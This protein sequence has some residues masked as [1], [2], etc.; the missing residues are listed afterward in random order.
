MKYE[1]TLDEILGLC[2]NEQEIFRNCKY[3]NPQICIDDTERWGETIESLKKN[4]CLNR[5]N[6]VG[7]KDE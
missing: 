1:E 2:G 5:A 6:W 7:G 4:Y 3:K